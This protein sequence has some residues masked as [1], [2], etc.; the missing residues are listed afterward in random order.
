MKKRF[1]ERDTIFSR[2]LEISPFTDNYTDYYRRNPER[3]E[4]DAKLREETEGVFSPRKAEQRQI[5]AIFALIKELR[6]LAGHL[7]GKSPSTS[8]LQMEAG[9]AAGRIK[10]IALSYGAL[11]CGITETDL[12]WAYSVRGRGPHYGKKAGVILPR[13]IVFTAE[14]DENEINRAPAVE[15]SVEVV[16]AYLNVAVIGLALSSIIRGWGWNAVCHMD[17]ESEL[18]LPP[19][20]EA[21]GLGSI[22]LPGLLVTRECGSRIR[23]G[24]V[25]TDMPLASDGPSS[26]QVAK[27]CRTCGKCA[28]LC[29]SGCIPSFSSYKSGERFS[30]DS[31]ACF[32]TWRELG[33]DCGVCLAACPYS[34]QKAKDKNSGASGDEPAA[35]FLKG[36]MFGGD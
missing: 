32:R 33:T 5:A 25:T 23:I 28:E 26:F 15:E 16:K 27:T 20:A 12:A 14:M 22:G 21:A 29:P 4:Q 3:E 24:A 18:V 10:K 30:I 8:A 9:P 13:T 1:D 17:G 31:E 7:G 2:M 11:S 6:P 35:D 19:A 36:F 34:H